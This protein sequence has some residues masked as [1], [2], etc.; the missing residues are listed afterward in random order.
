MSLILLVP[1]RCANTIGDTILTS[2][3][4][5]ARRII[6]IHDCLFIGAANAPLLRQ[7]ALRVRPAQGSDADYILRQYTICYV[8]YNTIAYYLGRNKQKR[9]YAKERMAA[10]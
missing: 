5:K 2:L 3:I 8:A 9:K 7:W 4:G 10:T 1:L 6:K